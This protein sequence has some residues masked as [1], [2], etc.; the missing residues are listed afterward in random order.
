MT[1][2]N[3][4]PSD[5]GTCPVSYPSMIPGDN[6]ARPVPLGPHFKRARLVAPINAPGSR[7]YASIGRGADHLFITIKIMYMVTASSSKHLSQSKD[8][9]Q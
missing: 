6:N 2:D 8:Y 3:S 4:E 1:V 7:V 9:S 5:R